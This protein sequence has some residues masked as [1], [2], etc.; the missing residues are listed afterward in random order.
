[1]GFTVATAGMVIGI[2]VGMAMI[3]WAYKKG[4]VKSVVSFENKESWEKTG[5]YLKKDRPSAGKQ[6]V[7]CDSIDSLAWHIVIIG[8]VIGIG[9][10]LY[11][12]IPLRGFPLFP[13]CM[14]AGILVESISRKIGRSLYIDRGQMERISG[15]SL[16]FLV[17]SAVATIRLDVVTAN[18]QPLLILIAAGSLWSVV[19]VMFFGPRIMKDAWFERS[20][21]EFGQAT[22]VTATGLMLLR[23]VDP[24]NKT[25]AAMAF[26]YKQ[27]LHEPFFGGGLWTA[28]AFSLVFTIGWQKVLVISAAMLLL[29][30]AF[31]WFISKNKEM[32][33]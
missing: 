14:I 19:V 29:W 2:I 8:V 12:L 31:G 18:W 26:G 32:F 22:G 27:L 1:M 16:D 21:A 17:V 30:L 11:S 4:Y 6:T 5:L 15:A 10:L 13:F 24:D 3:Q 25:V 28:M 7:L 20:I 33:S 9:F 23:T